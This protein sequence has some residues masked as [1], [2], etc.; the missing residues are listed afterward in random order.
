M[1]VENAAFLGAH[2]F[3]DFLLDSEDL[4]PGLDQRLFETIDFLRQF[5]IGQLTLRDR[6]PGFTGSTQSP[7][8]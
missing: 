5:H 7:R 4:L 3:D 2:A 1:R 6:R 8:K